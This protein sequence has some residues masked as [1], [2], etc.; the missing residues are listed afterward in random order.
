MELKLADNQ[1]GTK[2]SYQRTNPRYFI[3]G[4]SKISDPKHTS[5]QQVQHIAEVGSKLASTF[6][7]LHHFLTLS[8]TNTQTPSFSVLSMT[9]RLWILS[10]ILREAKV[11]AMITLA[12]RLLKIHFQHI[13]KPL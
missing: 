7:L 13:S 11:L 5:N 12:R 9:R 4:T 10:E 1:R 6:I 3:D 2:E 8:K